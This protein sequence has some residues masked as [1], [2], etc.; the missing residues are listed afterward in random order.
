[1]L[2]RLGADVVGMST[3]LEI[4]AARHLGVRCGVLSLITNVAAAEGI[5]HQEVLTE[6]RLAKDR[7]QQLLGALLAHPDLFESAA[8]RGKTA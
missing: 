5:D 6:G 8:E 7:V 4:I 1:M 3:V 2:A